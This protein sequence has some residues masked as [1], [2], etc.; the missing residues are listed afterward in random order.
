MHKHHT[1]LQS[2]FGHSKWP[3]QTPEVALGMTLS[4]EALQLLV[5]LANHPIKT[6]AK[7]EELT[8][9]LHPHVHLDHH[10]VCL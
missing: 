7:T 9:A 8:F 10:G 6:A 1:C 4:S 3:L 5:Q 2:C